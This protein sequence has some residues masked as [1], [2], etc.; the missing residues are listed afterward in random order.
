MIKPN[1]APPGAPAFH[2]GRDSRA[3]IPLHQ[4]LRTVTPG[5][6]PAVFPRRR[7]TVRIVLAASGI[8]SGACAPP[9]T[10]A[11]SGDAAQAQFA[12][13]IRRLDQA[14]A[15]YE[16]TRARL[17]EE[18]SA[19]LVPLSWA[20]EPGT[21]SRGT[22]RSAL[23]PDTGLDLVNRDDA[24]TAHPATCYAP[25][26]LTPAAAA[27]ITTTATQVGGE[28][29]LTGRA[30]SIRLPDNCQLT[31]TDEVGTALSVGAGRILVLALKTGCHPTAEAHQ[32]AAAGHSPAPSTPPAPR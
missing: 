31:L 5:Q 19:A 1:V 29:R 9:S 18:L 3:K 7:R 25:V 32:R 2:K 24:M 28:A 20:Q 17:R 14:L 27:A 30:P 11:N 4:P 16:R 13:L 12:D 15:R 10:L 23:W 26:S 6:A 8:F 21:N 22:C